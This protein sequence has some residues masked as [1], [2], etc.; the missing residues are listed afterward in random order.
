[1]ELATRWPLASG[2]DVRDALLAA[3][4][5]PGRRYHDL[6]HL[7]E[8]LDWIDR[9]S[10]GLRPGLSPEQLQVCRL[11]AWFHDGVYEGAGEDEERSARWAEDALAP[12]LPAGEVAE[13]ARLVRLTAG[14]RA[15]ADDPVGQVLCDA[16]LA[17]LAAGPQRYAE[18]VAAVRAEYAH[19]PDEEFRRGRAAIL[20]DLATQR[21]LYGT[22]L[23]LELLEDRAREN[24]RAELEQLTA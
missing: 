12:L 3:Y 18:Y 11:A 6:T 8:V 23:A 19:V 21:P 17:I 9:L 1:M 10:P 14:H 22:G 24:L 20:G 4:G 16:D 13:V 5:D 15:D 2:Q 7:S